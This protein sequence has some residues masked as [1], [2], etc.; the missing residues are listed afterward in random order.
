MS[1]YKYKFGNGLAFDEDKDILMLEEM[2]AEGYTLVGINCSGY[3][4]FEKAQ[5]EDCIY[6]VD[7]TD[8]KP[9]G[10]EFNQ[11]KEIFESSGWK[12]VCSYDTFHYF[13]AP[14][15]TTSIYTDNATLI[16]K[17]ETMRR[18]SIHTVLGCILAA[19]VFFAVAVISPYK[20]L[21]LLL[22][23][24]GV[25]AAG[26]AIVM[27]GGVSL[28]SWRISQLREPQTNKKPP[29]LIKLKDL[30]YCF[31]P[32]PTSWEAR[33]GLWLGY[34]LAVAALFIIF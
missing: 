11:Y 5:P 23:T 6:S 16:L 9:K 4:K 22:L 20:I 3:Y 7:Y 1:R 31:L 17:H 18:F 12:Y 25:M 10:E 19:V 24:L 29:L 33:L 27:T 34:I 13:K 30:G 15:G 28:N 26:I 32:P 8:L 2:S 21:S 14:K